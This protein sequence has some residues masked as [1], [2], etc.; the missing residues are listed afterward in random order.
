[1]DDALLAYMVLWAAI[2]VYFL[3]ASV[4]LGTGFYHLISLRRPE[5]AGVRRAI[6]AYVNP[7]WEVTNV[8]LVMI[9]V[10]AAAFLPGLVGILGT[11]LLIPVSLVA[12]VFV[13]RAAF[14]V[15]EY[16]GGE[17]HLFAAIYSLA[18]LLIL[19]LLSVVLTLII[20][21][22]VTLRG[23][24]ATFDVLSPLSH[25]VTYVTALLAFFGEILLSGTLALYYDDRTEDRVVYRAPVL[26]SAGGVAL[27]G[28]AELLL[29][30]SSAS[31]A[32]ANMLGL[33]PLMAVTGALFAVASFLVWRG[34]RREALYGFL[35]FVAVDALALMTFAFAH[36]PYL[37]Y[38]DITVSA[39]LAAPA[40]VSLLLVVLGAGLLAVVPSLIYL[41]LLFRPA[42]SV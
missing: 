6:H 12:M 26:A 34:T 38:P 41:N 11:V 14:L 36:Y 4:D 8:F 2:L 19:P 3:L 21:N 9:V 39:V 27:L 37:I 40:M 25:P 7:R 42:K 16:Y 23:G 20:D 13:I 1:M 5:G 32:F 28:I 29:L 31:Y 24:V 30:K 33:A 15:F 10:G 17:R 22:P 35:M 18:G